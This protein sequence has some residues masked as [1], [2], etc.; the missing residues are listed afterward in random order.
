[1]WKRK[2]LCLL[3]LCCA[4]LTLSS[5]TW[6]KSEGLMYAG[7]VVVNAMDVYQTQRAFDDP[8]LEEVNPLITEDT[9]IPLKVVMLGAV[10]LVAD[11]LTPYQRKWLFGVA[12]AL[13]GVVVLHNE[14]VWNDVQD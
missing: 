13:T 2:T 12:T 3:F 14:K 7:L 10:A 5:C 6:S 9:L 11:H 8:R 1:M 4:V